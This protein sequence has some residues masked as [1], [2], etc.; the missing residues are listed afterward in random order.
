ML[1][2]IGVMA[3]EFEANESGARRRIRNANKAHDDVLAAPEPNTDPSAG[4]LASLFS[5]TAAI[6]PQT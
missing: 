6:T 1:V 5:V 4:P 3:M 2:R